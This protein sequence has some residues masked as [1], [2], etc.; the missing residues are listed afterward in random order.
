MNSKTCRS[1]EQ[2]IKDSLEKAGALSLRLGTAVS[3][4]ADSISLLTAMHSLLG[5]KFFCI[6]VNH[7]IREQSETEGDALFV[8]K[9][10]HSLGV[11][12][13][14]I[15]IP[16]GKVIEVSESLK[17]GLEDAARRL[18]YEI[19]N[20]FI[21]E[22]K[23][24][25]LCLAH[26]QNDMEETVLMNFLRGTSVTAFQ[27][28]PFLRGKFL[29]PLLNTSRAEIETYLSE[30]NIPFRTD[31]SNSDLKILRNLFRKKIIPFLDK[32]IPFWKSGIKTSALKTSLASEVLLRDAALA[33]KKCLTQLLKNKAVINLE[34]FNSLLLYEK[35]SVLLSV[36][37]KIKAE[38]R[39]SSS[40]IDE[41]CSFCLKNQDSSFTGELSSSG[42]SFKIEK[43][44]LIVSP[45]KEKK[46]AT[47]SGFFVIIKESGTYTAGDL[48]FSA[49]GFEDGIL[50]SGNGDELF[51]KKLEFPIAVKSAVSD[52]KI[53]ASDGSPKS[54]VKILDDWKCGNLKKKIPVITE[55]SKN[56]LFS[57]LENAA[58]WGSV[59][60]FKKWVVL[61]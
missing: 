12:F 5:K 10:C 57:S 52:D 18:R 44:S 21:K 32:E 24:D 33:E 6:T 60:G 59:Y 42:L 4:G 1:F 55:L 11:D 3:G 17:C 38:E 23:L 46:V 15:D 37:S 27:G 50:F 2:K 49:E 30:K 31:S 40:F 14:R 41:V 56:A 16:R 45:A 8:E 39:V 29:R 54:I 13:T 51:V 35:H 43:G 7:N 28:I 53:C 48:E 61:K 47:D 26:N 36:L 25:F 9:Y 20:G 22:K 58:V 19:F 34:A